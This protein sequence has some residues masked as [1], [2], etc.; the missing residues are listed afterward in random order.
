VFVKV[1]QHIGALEFLVPTEYVNTMKVLH[2]QAPSSPL[3]GVFKIIRDE[4]KQEVFIFLL[5]LK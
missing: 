5:Q 3:E 1:G 2:S 4:L